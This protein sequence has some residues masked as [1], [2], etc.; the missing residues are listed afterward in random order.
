MTLAAF[1]IVR[2]EK[3]FLPLWLRYYASV[4]GE[5]N[6][7]VLDNE[8]SDGS[9][10]A[11][12]ASFPRAH[13]VEKKTPS[14]THHDVSWLRD[15]VR[16]FQHELLKDHEV[17][18]FAEA[19]EFLLA[20]PGGRY[21]DL[22][23]VCMQLTSDASRTFIRAAGWHVIHAPDEPA[24]VPVENESPLAHRHRFQKLIDYDKTLISKVPLDWCL[25]FH[26]PIRNGQRIKTD[27]IDHDVMLFH[28]WLLDDAEFQRRHK[29]RT[30]S[31]SAYEFGTL[32]VSQGEVRPIPDDWHKL[33]IW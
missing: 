11:A 3:L 32:H 4:V 28:A 1:T 25:G 31:V 24:L 6:C 12:K 23:D 33:L 2:D 10:L 9:V 20:R 18:V 8:T 30:I 26:D 27:P 15:T 19:D 17:V 21:S 5:E 16:S 29:G 13:F 22:R 14:S 7:Y